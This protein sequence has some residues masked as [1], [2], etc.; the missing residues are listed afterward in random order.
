MASY[1]QALGALGTSNLP[2]SSISIAPS[3]KQPREGNQNEHR[4]QLA[5]SRSS[6]PDGNENKRDR[7]SDDPTNVATSCD[8]NADVESSPLKIQ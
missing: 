7:P 3:L 2:S 8:L 6:S 1:T 4:V 5:L